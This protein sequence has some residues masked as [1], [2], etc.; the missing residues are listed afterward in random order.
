MGIISF[1][2]FPAA[3]ILAAGCFFVDDD[4]VPVCTAAGYMSCAVPVL[5]GLFDMNSRIA[6][7]DISGILDIYPAFTVISCIVMA[8]VTIINI[9]AY[10]IRRRK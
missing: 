3:V 9:T 6:D 7:G 2:A 10:I 1:M 4:K 8:A 5:S